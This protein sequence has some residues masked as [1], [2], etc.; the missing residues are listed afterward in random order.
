MPNA[1]LQGYRGDLV[2]L[3]EGYDNYSCIPCPGGC[4]NCDSNGV[5]LTFQEEVLNM[6]ACL[7]LL[8]A[9]VLGACILCCVVLSV[10]VFRQR[11]CKV[12]LVT[13]Y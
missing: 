4:T 1:T 9:I 5:C 13:Y 12:S 6:D 8:V 10:I 7:R 2:E 11:K 3:S